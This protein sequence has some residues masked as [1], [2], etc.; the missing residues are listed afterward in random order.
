MAYFSGEQRKKGQIL[1]V[2]KIIL[3]N[4][5]HKQTSF[6][7]IEEQDNLFQRKKGTSTPPRPNR[8]SRITE[9]T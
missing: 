3:G 5:K 6:K 4:R 8:A 7:G 2:T 9:A 1:R